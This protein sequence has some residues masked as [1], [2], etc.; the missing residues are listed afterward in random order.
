M[1]GSELGGRTAAVLYTLIGTCRANGINPHEYIA[2]V[3]TRINTHP[4]S[5]LAELLPHNWQ[6]LRQQK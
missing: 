5:K 6:R 2:D 1:L 3:L 4:Y